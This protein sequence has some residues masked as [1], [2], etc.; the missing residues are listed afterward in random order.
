[1]KDY[2]RYVS[3]AQDANSEHKERND[4]YRKE[5]Q[6]DGYLMGRYFN[7]EIGAIDEEVKR[8]GL[9][10]NALLAH[11]GLAPDENAE[12][13]QLASLVPTG[14]IVALAHE[15]IPDGYLECNGAQIDKRTYSKLYDSIGDLY[16]KSGPSSDKGQNG[17]YSDPDV[18]FSFFHGRWT[19]EKQQSYAAG[20]EISRPFKNFEFIFND[21]RKVYALTAEAPLNASGMVQNNAQIVCVDEL[22]TIVYGMIAFAPIKSAFG[23]DAQIVIAPAVEDDGE[24][25]LEKLTL[26]Y[27]HIEGGLE[28]FSPYNFNNYDML[29]LVK[30]KTYVMPENFGSVSY[31]FCLPDFRGVFLRGRGGNGARVSSELGK[32]QED[33]LQQHRHYILGGVR[34]PNVR[35][36]SH[37][38]G[39]EATFSSNVWGKGVIETEARLANE[40]RPVNY[41]VVYAV[42]Y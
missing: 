1:M 34:G 11:M 5:G 8:L 18:D 42:K 24:I 14:S 30:D 4:K 13:G 22:T 26:I 39:H 33:A 36:N 31:K 17:S 15:N 25:N 9:E 3:F 2:S 7:A 19:I 20:K 37:F 38:A 27:C 6:Q 32:M 21:Q 12:P 35:E 28:D 29:T 16:S 10:L 40:T 41:P 23:C